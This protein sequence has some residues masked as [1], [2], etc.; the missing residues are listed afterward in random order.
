LKIKFKIG[1]SPVA[2]R[3]HAAGSN[4][5]I[6]FLLN[7]LW[8][9]YFLCAYSLAQEPSDH[10]SGRWSQFPQRQ[11]DSTGQSRNI[12]IF[13]MDFGELL[14]R[15][16]R[17]GG[18]STKTPV[19]NTNLTSYDGKFI[20]NIDIRKV[21]IFAKS[22]LD[23]AFVPQNWAQQSISRMHISTRD[24]IIR[25]NLLLSP[26]QPLDVF[27]AA[28]NERL[29]RDMPYI[30]DARFL[31]RAVPGSEDSID[32]VVLTKDLVPIGFGAELSRA[33]AGKAG[34]WYYNILGYGNQFSATAFWDV[35]H[36]P[37]AG[38]GL[39]YGI[40]NINGS[41]V[42]GELSYMHQWNNHSERLRISR[43]FKSLGITY[44]GAIQ[45]ESASLIKDITLPDSTL[46]NVGIQFTNYDLWLGRIFRLRKGQATFTNSGIIL[47]GRYFNSQY[48]KGPG[49]EKNLFYPYQDRTQVFLAV[50]FTRQ[51]F[52]RDNMIY[53]FDRTE[54]VPFGYLF[55][56]TSGM[57][58]GQFQNRPYAGAKAS[59]GKIL[60]HGA[61]LFGDAEFGTFFSAGT[62]EQSVFRLQLRTFS[63]LYG[64]GRFQNRN[65]CNLTY[66]NGLNRYLDEFTTLENRGGI[67][68][69]SSPTLRGN[70]KLVLNL[71][72]VLFSPYRLLGFRFAFFGSVDLGMVWIQEPG[73]VQAGPYSRI[74]IGIRIR[75]E[76]L[77]FD[78]F[79]LRFSLYPGLPADA[80][81]TYVSAGSVPRLRMNALLPD[82]PDLAG[83]Y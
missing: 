22:A 52:R 58:W 28:E 34:L 7:A 82:K 56:I 26:G 61:T 14:D 11:S 72:S 33:D 13:G 59:F 16:Y 5:F 60:Q 41:F 83:Y 42:S 47:S 17:S 51:G 10:E 32:L 80:T 76:Q 35:R 73:W 1:D 30:M 45:I 23:T 53:T 39:T 75:N 63:R 20:R 9:G 24:R 43:D 27:L 15:I 38:Y 18:K 64:K 6:L 62:A 54:D 50:G 3:F 78:T 21:N 40:S 81:P 55:E 57:E 37:V 12:R 69:L 44:A 19:L 2:D 8:M 71:E 4:R 67:A 31:A 49:V 70:E 77:V 79:E 25:R 74:G 46:H 68:G 29:I 65:F 48:G 36:S 66:M